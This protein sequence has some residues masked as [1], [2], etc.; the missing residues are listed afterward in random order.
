MCVR[1][2]LYF[3]QKLPHIGLLNSCS[4]PYFELFLYSILKYTYMHIIAS[5]QLTVQLLPVLCLL[6]IL[7]WCSA[8]LSSSRR[9][10]TRPVSL[11]RSSSSNSSSSISN[12]RI[13]IAAPITKGMHESLLS[14]ASNSRNRFKRCCSPSDLTHK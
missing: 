4:F 1:Q 10:S 7:S 8:L 13:R 11:R 9:F 14:L 5:E 3:V 2:Q 12:L 6:P